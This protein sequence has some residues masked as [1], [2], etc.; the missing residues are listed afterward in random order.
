MIFLSFANEQNNKDRL[1]RWGEGAH[2]EDG[3]EGN[4]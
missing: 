1:E 4:R 2:G 3:G